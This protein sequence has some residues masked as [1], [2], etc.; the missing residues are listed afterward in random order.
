MLPVDLGPFDC[1]LCG[2][3]RDR[4]GWFW[5]EGEWFRTS[6]GT[7][8]RMPSRRLSPCLACLCGKGALGG[9]SVGRDGLGGRRGALS[10][11]NMTVEQYAAMLLAQDGAC[12]ICRRTAPDGVALSVDH[13]HDCC[14]W[15]AAQR[16][17]C[18]SC[19]RALLCKKCNTGISYFD[20]DPGR[21][22]AA[23][24]YVAKHMI[25]AT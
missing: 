3:T 19:N 15:Y 18:G 1:E 10:R 20:D 23:A 7:D 14:N 6:V 17:T 21:I 5:I 13:N 16:K 4:M 9:P 24:R 11:Y 8:A 25:K 12:A 2:N 22:L